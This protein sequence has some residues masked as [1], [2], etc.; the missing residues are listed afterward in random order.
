VIKVSTLSDLTEA[1][2]KEIIYLLFSLIGGGAN[3]TAQAVLI[4]KTIKSSST[5]FFAFY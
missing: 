5:P 4:Y 3:T 2:Y 1:I